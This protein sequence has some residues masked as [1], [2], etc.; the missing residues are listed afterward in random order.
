[1]GLKS[2]ELLAA[3]NLPGHRIDTALTEPERRVVIQAPW[4]VLFRHLRAPTR[5]TP[6]DKIYNLLILIDNKKVR[7]GSEHHHNYWGEVG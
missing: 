5:G 4:R 3:S 7:K 6:T 1:L 2:D